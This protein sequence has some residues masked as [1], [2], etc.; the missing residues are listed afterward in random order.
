MFSVAVAI[1]V[2]IPELDACILLTRLDGVDELLPL[3][4]LFFDSDCCS[5][6]CCCLFIPISDPVIVPN[7]SEV[8][9]DDDGVG[10][11]N[12][13]LSCCSFCSADKALAFGM[14]NNDD[15]ELNMG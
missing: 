11:R 3:L 14:S 10:S 5:C 15:P 2:F 13:G 1:N 7:G 6:C 8:D 12:G 4:L 9:G